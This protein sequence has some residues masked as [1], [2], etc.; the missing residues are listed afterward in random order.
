MSQKTPNYGLVKD[1]GSD[2]SS[3]V[4]MVTNLCVEKD[5]CSQKKGTWQSYEQYF[6]KEA[7]K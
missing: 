1:H 7:S 2:V 5:S 6:L 4:R 3:W